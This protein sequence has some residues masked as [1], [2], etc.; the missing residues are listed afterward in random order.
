MI[1]FLKQLR[2]VT[3][4]G[5]VGGSDLVKQKEQLG[6]D[7]EPRAR[8]QSPGIGS[9]HLSGLNSV[10]VRV[11]CERIEPTFAKI[12]AVVPFCLQS[13][14]CSITPSRRMG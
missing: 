6:D 13:W 4:I 14:T 8:R 10:L 7:G 12:L 1:D 11:Q 5:M 2:K 3:N 9:E